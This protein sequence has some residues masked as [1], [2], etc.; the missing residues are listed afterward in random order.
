[1][2]REE[3]THQPC[4]PER[5]R[6]IWP[7]LQTRSLRFTRLCLATVGMTIMV[8]APLFA[9]GDKKEEKPAAVEEQKTEEQ[10]PEEKKVEPNPARFAP[11][12]CDFEIT[13]PE[14][15]SIAQKCVPGGGCYEVNSYTMVY[16]LQTTV[17]ISVTCNPSTP[18]AYE[19]YSEAVMKAALAGMV[20]NRNLASHEVRFQQLDKEKV[21]NAALTGAGTTGRQEKIYSGQLWIGQ[22]SVFTVQAELVGGA[23]EVADKSFRDILS[24]IKT[25]EGKQM[26][27]PKKTVIP[28]QD[29]Q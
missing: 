5:S 28:K 13:F 29:N 8:S 14:A 11:D 9:A 19:K 4:H 22:N 26:P 12:F 17:D 1:M 24:S 6:G 15:P 7:V 18:A 16:D 25:K 10:K 23:H 2:D 27:K 3:M 20:E 21:K